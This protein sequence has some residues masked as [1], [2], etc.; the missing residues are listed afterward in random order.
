MNQELTTFIIQEL[1]QHRNRKDIVR[2]VCERAALPWKDAE[3][4]ITLVEAQHRQSITVP[5]TPWMLFLSIAALLLG[6]GV[7]AFN[8][9]MILAFFQ[10]DV[11]HQVLSLRTNSYQVIGL[12]TGLG[13][14]TSGLIG[15]W[16]A[17]GVMFPE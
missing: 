17:F 8:L 3:R 12:I 9:Q 2:K 1:A 15:L 16:R 11:L 10:Q 13:M 6:I 5:R 14:T 4:L 7:L